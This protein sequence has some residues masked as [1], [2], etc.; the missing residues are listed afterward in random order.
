MRKKVLYI[1][2]VV[3]LV[4]NGVLLY[5]LIQKPHKKSIS[6]DHFLTA[7][8]Q[9]DEDQEDRFHFFDREHRKQM[10]RIDVQIRTAKEEL[11]NSF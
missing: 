9:F 5:M 3:L 6:K 4:V 8:L 11:F 2:F 7:Q 10:R 1:F